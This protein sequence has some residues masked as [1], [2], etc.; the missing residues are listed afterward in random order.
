M[1]QNLRNTLLLSLLFLII[2]CSRYDAKVEH[3]LALAGEN[4]S[5]LKRVLSHYE[6]VPEDTLKFRAACYLIG[7]M[8]HHISYP[9]KPYLAY[10]ASLDSLFRLEMPEAEYN[11]KAKAISNHYRKLLHPNYD[12][13]TIT[14]DY[15]IRNIDYAF[16]QWETS[17]Y[18]RHLDFDAFC[19]YILP[20]KCLEGQPLYDWKPKWSEAGTDLKGI[21]QIDDYKYNARRAIEAANRD[22]E[23]DCKMTVW[24]MDNMNIMDIFELPTLLRR[25]YGSCRELAQL[26]LLNGR[27][28]SLP[29]AFDFTPA[30]PDRNASHSWN[31]LLSTCR[32]GI[33][34]EGLGYPGGA[35]YLDS[36]FGKVYRI[37]YA[38]HPLLLE[39]L[40]KEGEIPPSL[41]LFCQDV[42]A[43]YERTR[44]L[45]IKIDTDR[46]FGYLA[47]FDNEKWIPVAVG[48]ISRGKARFR[49]IP[50]GILYIAGSYENG[51]FIPTSDP[52]IVDTRGRISFPRVTEE[53][54]TIR[55][56]RKYPAFGHIH[57]VNEFIRMGRIEASDSP[58]FEQ[59][60]SIVGFP[61]W[62]LLAGEEPIADTLPR[63]YWRL[64]SSSAHS[65]DFAEIYFYERGTGKRITGQLIHPD[66]PIR[67]P[68][69]DIPEA[70]CDNDPLT[71]FAVE[72][73]TP[74]RWAGFDFGRPVSIERVAY[75]RRGD[76]NDI[77][78]GD[79]YELYY[80][81]DRRWVLHD[82]RTAEHVYL[83][84]EEVPTGGLYF[85]R[86]I[87]RGVQNRTFIYSDGEVVWY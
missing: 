67:N 60:D 20:Y 72:D 9:E 84:F 69:H 12:L 75:I 74:S 15:L 33:D 7:N 24:G 8:P 18:I 44:D 3:A 77:C 51:V 81:A 71:Y 73:G 42:T 52:F 10:C 47:T 13:L 63:R 30:W 34:F 64:M 25:P 6:S 58:R 62:H 5:E 21:A 66:A 32:H 68:Q 49:D 35:H 39:A 70:I 45:T 86:D 83:D 80:W 28:K 4:H 19:E 79:K 40:E 87:T 36:F 1:P 54:Q 14:A 16:S 31:S 26:V 37:S 23:K 61:E 17:P 2:G 53:R 78:P 85:I 41:P 82:R 57:H 43:E 29:V 59:A 46:K 76:G 55:M 48:R 50:L 65:S 22:Y 27:S 38:P 11:T 56:R